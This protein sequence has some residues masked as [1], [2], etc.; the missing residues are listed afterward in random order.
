MAPPTFPFLKTWGCRIDQPRIHFLV[1]SDLRIGE[2]ASMQRMVLAPLLIIAMLF[3]QS[4]CC[5]TFRPFMI[6]STSGAQSTE[7]S[8]CCTESGNVDGKCPLRSNDS[9]HKCPCKQGK[10]I[11]ARLDSNPSLPSTEMA[12]WYQLSYQCESFFQGLL[13]VVVP[14]KEHFGTSAFA[15]LDRA[16]ILRAVNS[17]RC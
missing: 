6:G 16:G 11:S 7:S 13:V 3:G 4:V 12:D 10:S 14:C 5:C 1:D 15:H 2:T 9:G 8:C 17:L